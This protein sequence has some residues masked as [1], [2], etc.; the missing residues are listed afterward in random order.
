MRIQYTITNIHIHDA[1]DVTGFLFVYFLFS[2]L[3]I[4]WNVSLILLLIVSMISKHF[5]WI[6]TQ[7]LM[8]NIRSNGIVIISHS[9]IYTN[10][11]FR[12]MRFYFYLYS[13]HCFSRLRI[14]ESFSSIIV[15]CILYTLH[16][17]NSSIA[18]SISHF[19]NCFTYNS[20]VFFFS[21]FLAG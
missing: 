19:G 2:L 8:S 1:V 7:Y 4:S 20:F 11:S 5:L 13:S 14:T 17:L 12:R 10:I 3:L 15:Y 16:R 18:L 21:S 9:F 6:C